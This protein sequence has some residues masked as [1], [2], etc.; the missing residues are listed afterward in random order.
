MRS[1]NSNILAMIM[2]MALA[3]C[4]VS[5]QGVTVG[6]KFPSF[7]GKDAISGKSIDL[8]DFRG[9]V[10][11]VD[12]WATWC[13]PCVGEI[14]NVKSVHDAFGDERFV[15][16]SISLDSDKAKCK[17]FIKDRGMDWYHI[18]DGGGWKTRLAKKYGINSIP[19][20]YLIDHN[21][22]CISDSAR[23]GKL[24]TE[25]ERAIK[26]IPAGSAPEKQAPKPASNPKQHEEPRQEPLAPA[27]SYEQLAQMQAQLGK[28]TE[29]L[30]RS[31]TMLAKFVSRIDSARNDL[32]RVEADL[33]SPKRPAST[34]DGYLRVRSEIIEL[35]RELFEFGLLNERSIAAPSDPFA[36]RPQSDLQPFFQAKT[37]ISMANHALAEMKQAVGPE[38]DSVELCR[39]QLAGV[40]NELK[41]PRGSA[42]QIQKRCDQACEEARAISERWSTAWQDQ[43]QQLHD[44]VAQLNV[45]T[46]QLNARCD[47]IDGQIAVIR[48]HLIGGTIDKARQQYP[49]MCEAIKELAKQLKGYGVSRQVKQPANPFEKRRSDDRLLAAE[50]EVQLKAASEA[51]KQMREAAQGLAAAGQKQA[52]AFMPRIKE[53]QSELADNAGAKPTELRGKYQSLCGE[54][55]LA[56]DKSL[57]S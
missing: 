57:H 56:Q 8:E 2:V 11:L 28:A 36:G 38:A 10:V 20:M 19:K 43:L 49:P 15:V 13:G 6:K 4:T 1:W 12:F 17:S 24:A 37:Q 31:T 9:K 27:I 42:E 16:I 52:E 33:P 55:L 25:V 41:S 3:L 50:A 26:K 51:V 44:V 18:V 53:L 14:P 30:E 35:R 46:A 34:R 32:T 54:I 47:E 7:T 29:D 48:E 22:V 39:V 45:P 23:G 21:G 40:A 5:A